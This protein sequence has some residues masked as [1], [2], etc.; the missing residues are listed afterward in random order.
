M[1]KEYFILE[2]LKSGPVLL[3]LIL[4]VL[5]LIGVAISNH[6]RDTVQMKEEVIYIAPKPAN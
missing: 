5:I 1:K 3:L 2:F 6:K 4:V